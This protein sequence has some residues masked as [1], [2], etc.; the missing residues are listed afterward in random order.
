V[1]ITR[2]AGDSTLAKIRKLVEDAQASRANLQCTTDKLASYFVPVIIVIALIVF[3]VWLGVSASLPIALRYSVSVLVVACPCALA[4]A[5]PS[6]VMVGMEVGARLGILYK[7]G[8]PALEN[9]HSAQVVVFDKTGTLTRGTPAVI[10]HHLALP[11]Q[12]CAQLGGE[13]CRRQA[14]EK[15]T[16][17]PF[18]LVQNKIKNKRVE[19]NKIILFIYPLTFF[20]G[21]T[22]CD[23]HQFFAIVGA[24]ESSSEHPVGRAIV[25]HAQVAYPSPPAPI[26]NFNSVPGKGITCEVSSSPPLPLHSLFLRLILRLER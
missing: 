23:T 19:Y 24:A 20:I 16:T 22:I 17:R 9:L 26:N 10:A 2:R 7:S 25:A 8:G 5:V 12:P 3:S 14:V 13:R 6:A 11:S 18:A 15:G 21:C 1:K 4:L